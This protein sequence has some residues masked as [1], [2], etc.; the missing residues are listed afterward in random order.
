MDRVRPARILLVDD[1]EAGRYASA[2]ALRHAGYEV[3]EAGAAEE[4]LAAL[5]A[6]PPELVILDIHLPGLSGHELLLR[7]KGD[8]ATALIPVMFLS[9]TFADEDSIAAGLEEGADA[10]LTKPYGVQVLLATV[11]SLLRVG[12]MQR[13]LA[14]AWRT[15]ERRTVELETI[16]SAA[17]SPILV[18]DAKGTLIQANPA[19]ARLWGRDPVGAD[20][21]QVA[22]RMRVRTLEGRLLAPEELP[23]SRALAGE[24][25]VQETY[26]LTNA[27]GREYV[28]QHSAAPLREE[29]QIRG[30]VAVW[31]D[32]TEREAAAEAVAAANEELRAAQEQARRE[33]VRLQ[34]V[35]DLLPVAV[36][37]AE[38]PAGEVITTNGA[39]AVLFE[40]AGRTNI[41]ATAPEGERLGHRYF[42]QGAEVLP[43][44]LPVQVAVAE[45]RE[46]REVE[47][48]A[49]LESGARKTLLVSATPLHDASGAVTGGVSA[50]VDITERKRMEAALEAAAAKY[51][52]MLETVDSGYWLCDSGGRFLEVNEAYCR[53]SG[54]SR[55]EL[56]LLSIAELEAKEGE[57]EVGRHLEL[58]RAHG[59][60]TFESQHRRKGGRVYDVEVRASYLDIEGGRLVAFVW[61][62]SARRAAERELARQ[63]AVLQAVLAEL[64][65]GVMIAEAPSGKLLLS[66]QEVERIWGPP[67]SDGWPG[68]HPDGRPYAPEEWPLARAVLAGEAVVDEEVLVRRRDGAQ[69][70]I[71]LGARPVHDAAGR[72]VA[73]VTVAH[74]VTAFRAQEQALEHQARLLDTIVETTP[75]W[76]AYLDRELRVLRANSAWV[77][78]TGLAAEEVVGRPLLEVLPGAASLAAQCRQVMEL[79]QPVLTAEHTEPPQGETPGP[80]R[81]YQI[82][83]APVRG[84]AQEIMGAVISVV[85]V[86]EQAQMRQR[87]V[88]AE[89]ARAALAEH[90]S[91]EIAHRVKNNLAMVSGLLQMQALTDT[92]PHVR[93]S[94]REA[95][96]RVQTFASLHE[97]MYNAPS[98]YVDLREALQRLV[99]TT[100]NVFGVQEEITLAVRGSQTPCLARHAT[101]LCVIANELI[102][103][104]LK[105]GTS[106]EGRC[107]IRVEVGA[108]EE[109][110][111]LAVW[112]FGRPLEEGFR[113]HGQPGMGLRLV[114]DLVVDQYQGQFELRPEG[115]GTVA[116]VVVTGEVLAAEVRGRDSDPAEA[117]ESRA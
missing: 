42:H 32:V 69:A 19:A 92:D 100:R 7:V 33:Q 109:G 58:V 105:H 22:Q 83:V 14:R 59:H 62:I 1:D 87:A 53:M 85:D 39:G 55:E 23:S 43:R 108:C 21:L 104:A 107:D 86:T 50:A 18:Y 117:G 74:D 48:E 103:N 114:W 89:R 37:I 65:V 61:D 16:F 88:T 15:A 113:L 25:V 35:M 98:E 111:R 94:L 27:R 24:H 12:R 56:L 8:P 38:D 102:T 51:A 54:Y 17:S 41:S 93:T 78:H 68:C 52:T 34:T 71:L 99:A 115:G 45:D 6:A 47:L 112:N 9:A 30:V 81:S 90:L 80:A 73:G 57:E 70:T 101:N 10:Y 91:D 76:L 96:A 116:E 67:A 77:A 72:V 5:A 2:R 11:A 20:R 46:V 44:A 60:D 75:N 79:G 106:A 82:G 63:Q 97:Q 95:V 36:M 4:A 49:H 29:G 26:R 84:E 40:T 28:V 31:H 110:L 13:E 64:P 3:Q 66:N